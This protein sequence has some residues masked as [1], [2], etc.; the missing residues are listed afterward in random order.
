MYGLH[1]YVRLVRFEATVEGDPSQ[2]IL[3]FTEVKNFKNTTYSC[4]TFACRYSN[5]DQINSNDRTYH[6]RLWLDHFILTTA[7]QYIYIRFSM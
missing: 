1:M 2:T 4:T 3:I 5:F 7:L 6:C